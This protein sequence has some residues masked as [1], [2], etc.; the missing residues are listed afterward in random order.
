MDPFFPKSG[1][2]LWRFFSMKRAGRDV[3]QNR[4]RGGLPDFGPRP[5]IVTF[6]PKRF[7]FFCRRAGQLLAKYSCSSSSLLHLLLWLV[8]QLFCILSSASP[9]VSVNPF[10]TPL[11]RKFTGRAFSIL[12][13]KGSTKP[14]HCITRLCAGLRHDAV[15][16]R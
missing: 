2:P 11:K 9:S 5:I 4:K 13:Q 12:R 7:G 14:T 10:S 16:D 1:F 6:L 8:I 15:R 3:R